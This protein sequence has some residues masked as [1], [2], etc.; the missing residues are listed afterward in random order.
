MELE[1]LIKYKIHLERCDC[2]DCKKEL[3][4]V[5]E[6]ILEVMEKYKNDK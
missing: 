1:K 3:K 6:K 4:F 5:N 2:E